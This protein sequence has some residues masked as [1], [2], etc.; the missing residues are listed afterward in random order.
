MVYYVQIDDSDTDLFTK[1]CC[2][3]HHG[4]L[5]IVATRCFRLKLFARLSM[6]QKIN[7]P[8]SHTATLITSQ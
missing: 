3:W 6:I 8:A 7:E 4:N 5:V 1:F 2:E